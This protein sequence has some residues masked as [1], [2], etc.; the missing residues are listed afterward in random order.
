MVMKTSVELC[1][2]RGRRLGQQSLFLRRRNR[3]RRHLRGCSV[4]SGAHS[5]TLRHCRPGRDS[6]G[7]AH[8]AA[9]PPGPR[10]YCWWGQERW[11]WARGPAIPDGR[12]PEQDCCSVSGFPTG[13][14][15]R[16]CRPP[17]EIAEDRLIMTGTLRA[18]ALARP[19]LGWALA[20]R[21]AQ[22]WWHR[23]ACGGRRWEGDGRCCGRGWGQ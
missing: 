17:G 9:S 12:R 13:A 14:G 21:R 8:T 19:F 7:R 6:L 23:P 18:R 20:R 15:R 4:A 10:G 5:D 16:G 3:L 1:N 22:E 11:G 2:E